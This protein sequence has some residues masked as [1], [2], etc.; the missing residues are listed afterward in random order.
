MFI[1][2]DC[3]KSI[4]D[5]ELM[6]HVESHGERRA[7]DCDCGGEFVEAVECE[8]CGRY[9]AG[10]DAR[11]VCDNCVSENSTFETACEIGN[12]NKEKIEINGFFY[13]IFTEEEVNEILLEHAKKK[14]FGDENLVN[15]FIRSDVWYF[16]DWLL[17]KLE[18]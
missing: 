14:V 1:C 10:D 17:G 2:T 7:D 18:K 8:I 15:K 11:I 13:E 6:F 3:G 12:E 16:E 9:M 4:G 5:D